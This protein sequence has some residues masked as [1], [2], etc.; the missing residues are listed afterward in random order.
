MPKALSLVDRAAPRE[1]FDAWLPGQAPFGL[2]VYVAL[3]PAG[4]IRSSVA[5]C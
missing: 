2:P 3:L 5:R 1:R 4:S